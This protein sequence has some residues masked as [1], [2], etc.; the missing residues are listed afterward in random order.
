MWRFGDE[1]VGVWVRKWEL[2]KF[3][4]GNWEWEDWEVVKSL[5]L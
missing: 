5:W 1:D 3:G 2:G 4:I